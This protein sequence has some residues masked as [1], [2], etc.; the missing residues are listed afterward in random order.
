VGD[1]HHLHPDGSWFCLS[2]GDY[3]LAFTASA[4]LAGLHTLDASFGIEAL[5]AAIEDHGA[6]E[7]FNTDQGSQ[8]TSE[9][10]TGV[11][12]QHGIQI[13]M[14]GKGRWVDS[15]FVERLWRS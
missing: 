7:I 5:K 1:R 9:E 13:C 10:F 15:V 12:K 3:G 8:F 2:G 14:D 11:L 6:P 4:L